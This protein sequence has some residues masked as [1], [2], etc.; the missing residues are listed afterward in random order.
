M[1]CGGGL[2]E[3]NTWELCWSLWPWTTG[4]LMACGLLVRRFEGCTERNSSFHCG[5]AGFHTTNPNYDSIIGD[6]TNHPVDTKSENMFFTSL[7]FSSPYRVNM[8]TTVHK[9]WRQNLR[10]CL[11]ALKGWYTNCPWVAF[12]FSPT[13]LY[14]NPFG[15]KPSS[16]DS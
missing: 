6:S 5:I 16:I 13:G 9:I 14:M 2:E 11:F 3:T 1:C 15:P 7:D 12:W 10:K 4:T 8:N